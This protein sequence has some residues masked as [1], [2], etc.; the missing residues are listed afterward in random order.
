MVSYIAFMVSF[1]ISW[2]I[3]TILD[4]GKSVEELLKNATV[5]TGEKQSFDFPSD[6]KD[7]YTEAPEDSE[8]NTET[9][10]DAKQP[11]RIKVTFQKNILIFSW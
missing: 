6:R 5:G 3:Y 9:S 1:L 11:S 8:T 10:S 4:L 2:E 7:D